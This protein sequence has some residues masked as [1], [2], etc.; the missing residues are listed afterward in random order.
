VSVFNISAIYNPRSY[1]LCSR[2]PLNGG[3]GI[4]VRLNGR[5]KF[6]ILFSLMHSHE[7]PRIWTVVFSVFD[8]KKF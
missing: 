6:R 2:L 3:G 8:E 4:I 5:K 7:E 1:P